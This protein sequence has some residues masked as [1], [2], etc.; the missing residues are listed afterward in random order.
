M[1]ER[2]VPRHR[3]RLA[4]VLAATFVGGMLVAAPVT[5]QELPRAADDLP[6]QEPGVTM[7]VFDIQ[8]PM[9]ELCTIKEGQT[10]NVDK[11]M[12]LID[13]SSPEEFGLD[14]TFVTH[15]IANLDVAESGSYEFRLIS[16]DGSRLYINDELV[17]DHDGLHPAEPKDGTVELEPGRHSLFIEHFEN[18]GGEHLTLAWQPP[19]ASEF[20][21]VPTAVLSTE[22]DVVRVTAPGR[23]ECEGLADTPGDGLVLTEVHPDY[24]LTDLRPEGFEPQV[25]AMD[26]MPDGRMVITTWGDSLA[27]DG[28][29]YLLGNVTGDTSP[30]EVTVEKVAEGLTRADGRRG[31]RRH[32][33]RLAETRA[34]RI[35]RCRR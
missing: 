6:P 8:A 11:L 20:E 21:V 18:F 24:T 25:T 30:D 9:S 1:R 28:E 26:W 12:P 14:S 34:H 3:R 7:R 16:D 33:L 5:A 32:D 13:W 17:V 27:S 35:G 15:V 31:R 23:K 4:G 29:V 22:A 10:P 19:G 2:S